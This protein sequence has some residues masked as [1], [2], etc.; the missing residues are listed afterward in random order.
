MPV[1]TINGVEIDVPDTTDKITQPLRVGDPVKLL[2]K[3]QYGEPVVCAG[4]VANFE[5]FQSLPTITIAYLE[6]S[7]TP[8]LKFAHL[9]TKSAER[10]ELVHGLDRQLLQIDRSRIEQVL[11][12][13]VEKKQ[14]DLDDAKAKTALF[15]R[16]L[17]RL[18]L[19]RTGG[20]NRCRGLIASTRRSLN[21]CARA[22][23][24]VAW[25]RPSPK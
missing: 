7:Y 21:A 20:R 23:C 18:L 13:D 24:H 1:I 14:R 22:A 12:D 2:V 3:S 9:N 8:G 10:Y 15:R 16:A 6:G 19:P 4:V 5:M 17:R 11:A 25:S